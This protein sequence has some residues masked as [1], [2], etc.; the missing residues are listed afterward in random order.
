MTEPTGKGEPLMDL[1]EAAAFLGVSRGTLQN[2]VW[3]KRVPYVKLGPG[4][5][6]L[7]KFRPESL[8]AWV[9]SREVQPTEEPAP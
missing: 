7:T 2:W 9:A 5:G 4:R 8:R 6:S 1:I 3:Q